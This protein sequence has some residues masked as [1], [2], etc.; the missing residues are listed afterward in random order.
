MITTPTT[1]QEIWDEA[2]R[3]Y[4]EGLQGDEKWLLACDVQKEIERIEE[5]YHLKDEKWEDD[6]YS[7]GF[8]YAVKAIKSCL[9]L[10]EEGQVDKEELPSSLG[11]TLPS[12]SS[13]KK[14]ECCGKYCCE[15]CKTCYPD[16]NKG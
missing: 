2:H 6:A 11:S 4:N 9:G 16:E 12:S 8:K 7:F 5:V 1:T 10:L 14:L 3:F 15:H 13:P